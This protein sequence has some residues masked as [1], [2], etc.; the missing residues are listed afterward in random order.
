MTPVDPTDSYLPAPMSPLNTLGQPTPI[1]S[2]PEYH[3]PLPPSTPLGPRSVE[4]HSM[5]PPASS[6]PQRSTQ[7]QRSGIPQPMP[8][9]T[10]NTTP[11]TV[12][13]PGPKQPGS[14]PQPQAEDDWMEGFSS[15]A[16]QPNTSGAPKTPGTRPRIQRNPAD[17]IESLPNPFSDDPQGSLTPP[18][19]NRQASYWE[20]W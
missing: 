6:M 10:P 1:E 16:P 20:A 8:D 12:P 17:T 19:L 5:Q 15:E 13:A 4:S 9:R 2:M 14:V 7:P 11:N 18:Q 3:T